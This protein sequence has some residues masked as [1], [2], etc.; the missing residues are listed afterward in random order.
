MTAATLNL[1][2]G[3]VS[4]TGT[5]NVAGTLGVNTAQS[6]AVPLVI[7]GT[8]TGSGA[9]T[10]TGTLTTNGATF[11]GPGTVTAANGSTWQISPS[12]TTTVNGGTLVNAGTATIEAEAT[13][14][15]GTGATVTN[16]G[17]LTVDAGSQIYGY[18]TN[19]VFNNAGTVVVSPGSTGTVTFNGGALI[20]NNT[21]SI[22]LSSGTLEVT[23]ATL[24][25]NAGSV[26][27]TGT[28]NVAGT[29]GVNTAQSLAVSLVISGTV[30]GSGA[31][32]ITGTLTT[33]GATFAGPGTVTAANGSTWQI[34]PSSTTT[35]NGGTLVNAGTVVL[36]NGATLDSETTVTNNGTMTMDAGSQI[37]GYATNS[38]FTNT[39]TLVATPGST[40]TV[41]LYGGALTVNNTGSIE[42]SSGTLE[43][44]SAT[45]NLNAGSVGGTGTLNVVGT[46]GV[47][48]I[49][50]LAVPLV[51]SGTVTGSGALN[52]AGTLTTNGATFDGPGTVTAASGST[53]QVGSS[54]TTTVDGGTLVNAGTATIDAGATLDIGSGVTVTN[55]GTMTMDA[56]SQIY[57]YYTNSVVDNTGTLVANPGFAKTATLFGGDLIVN[58]TGSIQLSTGT[59]EVTS[60]TLNLNAGSVS[61]TGTLDVAGTLAVNTTQSVDALEVAG[62]TVELAAG[63]TLNATSLDSPSG[64]LQLDAAE[65]GQFGQVV[66]G[67]SVDVSNLSLYL[68]GSFT[69]GCGASVTAFKASGVSGSLNSVSGPTPAEE[70]G[71]HPPRQR[72]PAPSSI[73]HHLPPPQAQTYGSGSS[74]DAANTAGYLAEPVNTATGAYSTTE[75]DGETGWT[76]RPLR[77]LPLVFVRRHCHR[78]TGTGWTDSMNV[79]AE[80]VGQHR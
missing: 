72:Q 69:P 11:A 75:T 39:G 10:I 50:S 3:S 31:L 17:T 56:G 7:S 71:R 67:G 77:F 20:V 33:N 8:V 61:G 59:L 2:A 63:V 79:T 45:L 5:L 65:P 49:Q 4:G 30:T 18:A 62:G 41:I 42:L 54:S 55:N 27:G 21:G 64:T 14:D 28:L 48:T 24:N 52:V 73:A 78:T 60:A 6:L 29:L 46:L 53:W 9:L 26:S 51:I 19:S 58:N 25:L 80:V 38:T 16:N 37:Y 13:L 76:R 32:T 34:S 68:N 47:N 12:S 57:G 36:K 23:A 44:S 66:G 22:E 35:V 15:I 70:R 1:N 74:I 43:V 40:G